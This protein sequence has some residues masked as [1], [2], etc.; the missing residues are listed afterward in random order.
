LGELGGR[1]LF[2]ELGQIYKKLDSYSEEQKS[3]FP[4]GLKRLPIFLNGTDPFDSQSWVTATNLDLSLE[5]D[6][7]IKRRAVAKYLTEYQNLLELAGVNSPDIPVWHKPEPKEENASKLSKSM[8]ESL[9]DGNK[10]PFNNVLFYIN[11]ENIFANSSILI[12]AAPYFKEIFFEDLSNVYNQEYEDIEPDSFRILLRWL[13]GE[14]LSQAIENNGKKYDDGNFQIY[15]DFLIA[16]KKFN[17]ESIK[18][19]IEYKLVMYINE[20]LIDDNL[21]KVKELAEEYGL[22]DLLE[23]CEKIEK[24]MRDYDEETDNESLEDISENSNSATNSNSTNNVPN[25][26]S[27]INSLRIRFSKHL[28]SKTDTERRFGS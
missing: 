10:T 13:Y 6:F 24:I 16:S 3:S 25:R 18:E 28:L 23:F 8:I 2:D 15:Q 20:D 14:P 22:E 11:G 1:L 26:R 7:N 12:C 19:L 9:N 17:I 5:R 4:R 21:D 27:I